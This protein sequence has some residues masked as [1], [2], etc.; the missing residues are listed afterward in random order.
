MVQILK[1]NLRVKLT[2]VTTDNAITCTLYSIALPCDVS[3][4]Q[5]VHSVRLHQHGWLTQPED[6][7]LRST[8][9]PLAIQSVPGAM[10][11]A[12]NCKT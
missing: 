3:S 11:F 9:I 10:P 8:A 1:L 7:E 4:E 5:Q 2:Q 6:P 12:H